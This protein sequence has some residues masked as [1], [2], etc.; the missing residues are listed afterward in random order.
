M[1]RQRILRI[2]KGRKPKEYIVPWLTGLRFTAS[3]PLLYAV[4][5]RERVILN[6]PG[7]DSTLKWHVQQGAQ[8]FEALISGAAVTPAVGL[9]RIEEHVFFS[10]P[11]IV[12]SKVCLH[13][14][15]FL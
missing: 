3:T 9:F 4:S 11:T 1:E 13:R 15:L 6:I 12:L 8:K 2:V 5:N 10:L 14:L 7:D